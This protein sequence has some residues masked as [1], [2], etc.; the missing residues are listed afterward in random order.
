VL[1]WG[2]TD[3]TEL[4]KAL[5]RSW[6]SLTARIGK[7]QKEG[8]LPAGVVPKGGGGFE[9]ADAVPP[10]EKG[11]SGAGKAK[12]GSGGVSPGGGRG[13]PTGT[14]GPDGLMQLAPAD[15]DAKLW[16]GAAS[17]GWKGAR[18]PHTPSGARGDGGVPDAGGVMWRLR[19]WRC[20]RRAVA[21]VEAQA[22]GKP[23]KYISPHGDVCKNRPEALAKSQ[24]MALAL[25]SAKGLMKAAPGG[26]AKA[27]GG[28]GRPPKADKAEKAA[29]RA[30]DKAAVEAG[31]GAD[32]AAGGAT[33]LAAARAVKLNKV[34]AKALKG[35]YIEI[36][37]DG[38][39]EWFEAEVLAYDETRKKHFVRYSAD[40]YEC[41][42]NLMGVGEEPSPWRHVIKT[43]ARGASSKAKAA[44]SARKESGFVVPPL[45]AVPAPPP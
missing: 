29:E 35:K 15:V 14:R 42:E 4:E 18:T 39:A 20:A 3:R 19:V 38:E 9:G 36:Y 6:G 34:Q 26:K 5:K 23:Y 44:E 10:S 40:L 8:K 12:G 22:N 31:G 32:A 11:S 25:P 43:T 28:K 37:W 30:A 7:L 41:E 1:R 2:S 33:T 27:G 16:E 21:V 45:P 24:A 13:V 17:S